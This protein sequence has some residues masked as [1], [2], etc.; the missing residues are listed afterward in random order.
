LLLFEDPAATFKIP[1]LERPAFAKVAA[2][3]HPYDVLTVSELS[4]YAET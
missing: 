3:A 1:A 2:T 4:G